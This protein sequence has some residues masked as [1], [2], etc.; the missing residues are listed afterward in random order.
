MNIAEN[1]ITIQCSFMLSSFILFLIVSIIKIKKFRH[2]QKIK[3]IRI[4]ILK[5]LSDNINVDL[6]TYDIDLLSHTITGN[7]YS[8][9][10]MN[11]LFNEYDKMRFLI[12]YQLY[13]IMRLQHHPKS[14][15]IN[16]KK[17]SMVDIPLRE[18]KMD[19]IDTDITPQTL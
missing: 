3:I 6:N 1:I 14:K 2:N 16:R 7:F 12:L 15:I 10:R 9:H 17:S 4:E 13:K 5:Y 11:T 19:D 18:G 8:N